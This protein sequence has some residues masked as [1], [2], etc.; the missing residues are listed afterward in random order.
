MHFRKRQ[1]GSKWLN[2]C[3]S[4]GFGRR[5]E[6]QHIITVSHAIGA[7]WITVVNFLSL[8]LIIFWF[9]TQ[10]CTS[11]KCHFSVTVVRISITYF[12]IMWWD[13]ISILF[14]HGASLIL[15][16]EASLKGL[17]IVLLIQVGPTLKET[18]RSPVIRKLFLTFICSL[19]MRYE[20]D[21]NERSM[22]WAFEILFFKNV[23]SQWKGMNSNDQN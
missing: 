10:I 1:F 21:F 9:L 19:I 22:N 4:E 2:R 23:Q 18:L 7:L 14:W 13:A 11:F 3:V 6:F 16:M 15:E 17:M 20:F 12:R 5:W 8:V